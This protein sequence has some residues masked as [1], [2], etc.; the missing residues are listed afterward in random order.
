[1]PVLFNKADQR[2]IARKWA[3]VAIAYTVATVLVA[4]TVIQAAR[5][6]AQVSQSGIIAGA[7]RAA[8][9]TK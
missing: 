4:A 9:G 8:A 6:R 3:M 1:V 7:D 2:R 5:P